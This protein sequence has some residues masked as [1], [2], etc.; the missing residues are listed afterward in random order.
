MDIQTASG[1][2]G[3]PLT[4]LVRARFSAGKVA[5]PVRKSQYL[6]SNLKHI[7]G[8]PA[9]SRESGYSL[10]KLKALDN[11]IE[12]LGDYGGKTLTGLNPRGDDSSGLSSLI[13][14]YAEKLHSLV[15]SETPYKSM[16]V[17]NGLLVNLTV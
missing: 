2:K 15:V 7:T 17:E 8:I 14:S 5:L 10:T 3:I 6:Y 12:R 9:G 13:E 4:H 1:A 16:G 11:L